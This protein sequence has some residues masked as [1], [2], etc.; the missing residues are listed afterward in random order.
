MIDETGA[1]AALS[2]RAGMKRTS[3]ASWHNRDGRLTSKQDPWR[4]WDKTLSSDFLFKISDTDFHFIH[5]KVWYIF[6]HLF[7]PTKTF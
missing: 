4:Q 2:L 3:L 5:V 6:Q 7:D 1:V